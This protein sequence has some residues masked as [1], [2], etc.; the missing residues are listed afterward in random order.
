MPPYV[1]PSQLST[2]MVFGSSA[3]WPSGQLCTTHQ[4]RPVPP[5]VERPSQ[6]Q[7]DRTKY[8]LQR[9]CIMG[10]RKCTRRMSIPCL[11]GSGARLSDAPL[12]VPADGPMW[13]VEGARVVPVSTAVTKRAS[14]DAKATALKGLQLLRSEIWD[15]QDYLAYEFDSDRAEVLYSMLTW[16]STLEQATRQGGDMFQDAVPVMRQKTT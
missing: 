14:D 16:V 12:R 5:A 2:T 4:V 15:Q 3:W 6:K 11:H 13:A 10:H 7:E 9:V 1:C 8:H